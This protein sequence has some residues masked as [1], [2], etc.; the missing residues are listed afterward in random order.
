MITCILSFRFHPY[1]VTF[2]ENDNRV[3]NFVVAHDRDGNI[4]EVLAQSHESFD[5][6]EDG[7]IVEAVDLAW[8]ARNCGSAIAES[9]GNLDPLPF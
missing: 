3:M 7:E 4:V 6:Y 2:M 5:H 1:F 9:V 8:V